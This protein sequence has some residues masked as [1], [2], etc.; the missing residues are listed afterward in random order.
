MTN[1]RS[2]TSMTNNL[3]YIINKLVYF[4]NKQKLQH[5]HNVVL[6]TAIFFFIILISY[7]LYKN[8]FM[9]NNTNHNT[10]IRLYNKFIENMEND[11]CSNEE[12]TE[13][14]NINKN[15]NQL[16][17]D[18]NMLDL[19][20]QKITNEQNNRNQSLQI[21]ASKIEHETDKMGESRK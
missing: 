10:N 18:M 6:I 12:K 4:L 20:I 14:I 7:T 9:S 13:L 11:K 3:K 8:K 15:A 16:L 1:M 17:S 21:N 2:M 19:K 5:I